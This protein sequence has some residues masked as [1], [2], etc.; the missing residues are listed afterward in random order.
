MNPY[1]TVEVA[2]RIFLAMMTRHDAKVSTSEHLGENEIRIAF[3]LAETFE[4]VAD[5][6]DQK[7][8]AALCEEQ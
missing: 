8:D 1:D 6:H 5:E 2:L 7:A 3:A 4:R